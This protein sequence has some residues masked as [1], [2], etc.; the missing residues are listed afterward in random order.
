MLDVNHLRRAL[1]TNSTSTGFTAKTATATNPAPISST[2]VADGL[3]SGKYNLLDPKLG[4]HQG[5]N[6]GRYVNI[7]PFGT[8]G[9]N[10]TFDMRLW[11]WRKVSGVDLWIPTL[12]VQL[13]VILGDIVAT[14]IAA[15]N[16]LADTIT[17]DAGDESSPLISPENDTPGMASIHLRGCELIEFDWDLA[18]AQEGVSMNCYWNVFDQ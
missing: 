17:I 7:I 18:G 16:Y 14:A 2:S 13:D 1:T 10:D 3:V 11:G 15:D 5:N 8:N 4:L 12:L 6:T 9:N